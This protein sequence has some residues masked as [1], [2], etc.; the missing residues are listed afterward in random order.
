L[1]KTLEGQ[2]AEIAENQP[3][4]LARHCTEAGLIEK[5][6]R[7]WGKAGQQSLTRSALTEAAAQFTRALAQL[8]TLATTPTL[9][10]DQI[11]LQVGLASTQM[12]T[13]GYAASETKASLE[14]AQLLIERAEALGET[15]DDPL[16]LLSVL[17]GFWVTHYFAFNGEVTRELATQF[18][19]LAEK[20]RA[21][22]VL[23]DRHPLLRTVR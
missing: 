6:S 14:Q 9:R 11:K 7:L 10:R 2:F 4:M 18:L 20:Q 12:Q 13:K 19:A 1:W 21:S 15:P 8:E 16:L 17:Y 23:F 3:E 5:A 22:A